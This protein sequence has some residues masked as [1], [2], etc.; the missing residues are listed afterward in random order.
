MGASPVVARWELSRRLSTRR[1]EL[2]LDVKTI[3]EALGFTRNYWSAVENDRTL[4]ADDKLRQ[5]F[6]VLS[7]DTTDQAE[8][9]QLREDARARSWWDNFPGIN[10]ERRRFVGLEH[11]ATR[12]RIY[13]GNLIPGILQTDDYARALLGTDPSIS[14]VDLEGVLLLRQRRKAILETDNPPTVLVILGEAAIHQRVADDIVHAHQL[15]QLLEITDPLRGPVDLRILP[16]SS[17]PGIIASSSTLLFLEFSSSH[18]P[19]TAW[20]EA[21][22]DVGYIPSDEENFRILQ[23]SWEDGLQRA[24]SRSESRQ[25]LTKAANE[26]G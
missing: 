24:H 11:G 25:L 21:V 13:E 16:F 12:I 2:G 7:F 20:Q 1:K 23:L 6:D 9:L 8:L 19:V 17:N 22:R 18:L 26:L 5:L 14:S 10:D 15:H 3:T 4:I